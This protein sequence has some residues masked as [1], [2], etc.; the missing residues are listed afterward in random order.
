MEHTKNKSRHIQVKLM[1]KFRGGGES[2]DTHW[3]ERSAIVKNTKFIL[4]FG[5]GSFTPQ[6]LSKTLLS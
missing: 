1:L 3:Y 4:V 5:P 2:E 6:V